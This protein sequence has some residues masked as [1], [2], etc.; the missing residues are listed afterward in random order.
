MKTIFAL[1]ALL[2]AVTTQTQADV[3]YNY[4]GNDYTAYWTSD[5][6]VGGDFQPSFPVNLELGSKLTGTVIFDDTI[7]PDFN[8]TV[9]GSQILSAEFSSGPNTFSYIQGDS[10][11][12][13][14]A[15]FAFD[16]G[17]ITE[18]SITIRPQG[19]FAA[20][21]HDTFPHPGLG[22]VS[23][24]DMFQDIEFGSEAGQFFGGNAVIDNPGT[25]TRLIAPVP[26]PGSIWFFASTA[27]GLG[28]LQRRKS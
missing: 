4:A 15:S 5:T 25:W 24:F 16:G 8:G 27:L 23:G 26:L 21:Y 17:D 7:V 28:F 22:V 19:S 12:F 6:S 18:A 13:L 9:T 14:F 2:A 11:V 10:S 3:V 20:I 1:G